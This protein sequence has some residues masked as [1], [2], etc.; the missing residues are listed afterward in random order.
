MINRARAALLAAWALVLMLTSGCLYPQDQSPGNDVTAR[1]AVLAVQNAVD[2]YKQSTGLLPIQNADASVPT[3]E[4][5]RI[6]F[7]KMK[8]MGYLSSIPPIAFENGGDYVFLVIDEET[9]P[10]VKLLDVAVF[11]GIKDV[12]T[13]VADYRKANN[14][15]NP[16]GPE[17][18][19]G[20]HYLNFDK[21]GTSNPDLKSMYSNR[22]LEI[23]VDDAGKVYAD[24][25]IDIAA[26]LKKN[27]SPPKAEE[28]LRHRLTEASD[29]APVQSPVYHWAGEGPRAVS[30]TP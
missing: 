29:F 1:E 22:P 23:M 18:Y 7:G 9:K 21:L 14:G 30:Q 16:G 2:R 10:A 12:Q 20:F 8:R 19:S 4:K 25:G 27:D 17:A 3:Y 11:Q 6:D 28:D 15:A 5:F 26:A 24:Y 13:K